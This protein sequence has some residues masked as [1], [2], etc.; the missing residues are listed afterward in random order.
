MRDKKWI[1]VVAI[2]LTAALFFGTVSIAHAQTAG[3][4]S[5]EYRTVRI[6][7]AEWNNIEQLDTLG[8]DG[9]EL[10]SVTGPAMDWRFYILFFK[11]QVR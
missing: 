3:S 2:V 4:A 9:W 11:R 10:V 5:W 1:I 8:R 6:P 7:Q